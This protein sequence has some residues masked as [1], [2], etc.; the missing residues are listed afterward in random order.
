MGGWRSLLLLG[1]AVPLSARVL[2]VGANAEFPTVEAALRAARPGDTV[3]LQP[4]VYREWGLV[5]EVP[6]VLEG[7]GAAVLDA[8][9]GGE[10]LRVRASG[11]TIR[12]L[13]LRRSGVSF[14]RD[15]AAIRLDSVQDCRIERNRLEENF[16][17]IYLARSARCTV[18][19]NSILGKAEREASAGNGI[20]LWYCRDILVRGNTIAGHRDGIYFE[21]V[22]RSTVE[23]NHS[24]RNLRYGLHFMFSD[25][26]LYRRNRFRENRAGV[27]VMY[28][29]FI[30]MEE[31]RFEDNWGSSVFGLLLKDIYRSRIRRNVFVH[32]TVGMY[33]EGS[34]HNVVDSNRFE[35][36]GWAL[37]LMASAQRN[38]FRAN[39]FVA[40]TFDLS[41]NSTRSF[42]ELRGNYWSRYRGYDLDGDGYGDVPF[43][44]VGLFALL[45]E[46]FPPVVLFLHSLL[47][48]LLELAERV[49]PVLTPAAIVDP[50]PLMGQPV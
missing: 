47:V 13:V 36:N 22:Q 23:E 25:S 11:V 35:R 4:G 39:S 24:E 20:H 28:S 2:W 19:E 46:R 5:V 16:F 14:L 49:F 48:E 50:Q 27:A 9:G 34:D 32:N 42:N 43:H 41:T 7:N 38:V 33:V 30:T 1:V 10:I 44:P 31:N 17:G 40:N 6:I 29:R 12:G 18:Q 8:E 37:R 45:V 15:N 21:F 3:R 26:C